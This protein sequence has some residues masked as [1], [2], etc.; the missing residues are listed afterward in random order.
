[1]VLGSKHLI[2]S[3]E[4]D[5]HQDFELKKD[6]PVELILGD[7]ETRF[8]IE[9]VRADGYILLRPREKRVVMYE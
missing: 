2:I 1:M 3:N 9:E 5:V 4:G 7:Q 8:W 6:F